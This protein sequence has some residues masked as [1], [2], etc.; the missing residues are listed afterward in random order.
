MW[1]ILRCRNPGEREKRERKAGVPRDVRVL[2]YGRH[3]CAP[4]VLHEWQGK[5]RAKNRYP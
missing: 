2:S 3:G 4:R 5:L 1:L